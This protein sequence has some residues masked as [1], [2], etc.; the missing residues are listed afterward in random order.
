MNETRHPVSEIE[1]IQFGHEFTGI[2]T[3]YFTLKT[4]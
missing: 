2:A 1:K 4:P 3:E